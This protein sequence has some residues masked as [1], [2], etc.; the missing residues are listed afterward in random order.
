MVFFASEMVSV[1]TVWLLVNILT[2]YG[3]ITLHPGEYS[4]SVRWSQLL[5]NLTVW[6]YVPG[7]YSLSVRWSQ[8][9][10]IFIVVNIL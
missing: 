10:L 1:L 4:L 7:E 3:G 5:V 6:Y 2:Q 8:L 9:W